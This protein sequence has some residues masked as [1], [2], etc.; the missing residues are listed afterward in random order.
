LRATR[1][2]TPTPAIPSRPKRMSRM[3][4]P[5]KELVLVLDTA[6]ALPVIG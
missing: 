3:S 5:L 1:R 2:T 4:P 6:V